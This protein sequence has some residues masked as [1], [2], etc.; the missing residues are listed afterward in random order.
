MKRPPKP[1]ITKPNLTWKWESATWKPYYRVTWT[2][3]TKRRERAIRLNW[4]G[5]PQKLDSEYW[6][7]RGGS[8]PKQ[9]APA[10][11]TWK[12]LVI[13]WRSDPRVQGKLAAS[14]KVSYRRTMDT[15][16]EK[17]A[18]KDTR[19]TTRKGLRKKHTA[20]ADVTRKADKYV[21]TVRLLL[22]YAAF[23]LDWPMGPN[24]ASNFDFYGAQKAI[25]PWPAWMVRALDTAPEAV[26]TTAMLILC[27]GQR[28]GAAVAMTHNQ[29]QGEYMT[30]LDEKAD[31]LFEVFCPEDLRTYLADVPKRGKHVLAKNLTQPIGYD[32]VEKSFRTW[33]KKMGRADALQYSLHGLRK[34]AIVTLAEAGCTDAEI[35]AV[36]NQSAEMVAYYRKR[37]SRKTLS[38]AAQTRRGQSGNES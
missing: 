14:T 10:Q 2:E 28:P 22:N 31:T 32:A 23:K 29:F 26:R 9:T 19:R 11:Y 16:L 15:I 13:E 34:L 38:R 6:K 4:Q 36:T 7:A 3:G 33:R 30:V 37:A 24:P 21:E 17:N 20:M 8:H 5:D 25:E 27:T 12:E 1:R 35:Q 18:T